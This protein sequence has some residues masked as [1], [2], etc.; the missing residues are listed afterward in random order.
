[1]CGAIIGLAISA[2]TAIASGVAQA[3]QAEQQQAAIEAEMVRQQELMDIKARQEGEEASQQMS[4]RALEARKERSRLNVAAGESG[5]GGLLT[6]RFQDQSIFDEGFDIAAI[7]SNR[8]AVSDQ[9]K[10]EREGINAKGLSQINSLDRPSA[11]DIGLNIAGSV[12]NT[13]HQEGWFKSKK[14]SVAPLK[15]K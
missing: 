13:G 9:N 6:E 1:M 2:V 5:L 10:L 11:L 14:T 4:E 3:K 8:A 7:E 15:I 12:A